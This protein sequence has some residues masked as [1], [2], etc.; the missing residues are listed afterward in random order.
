LPLLLADVTKPLKI[1]LEWQMGLSAN[2]IFAN[3]FRYG[4]LPLLR[5]LEISTLDGC[6]ERNRLRRMKF[7]PGVMKKDVSSLR[8]SVVPDDARQAYSGPSWT[9]AVGTL[10]A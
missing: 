6:N 5:E 4:A 8:G 7:D 10:I 9:A 1:R 3:W 2:S